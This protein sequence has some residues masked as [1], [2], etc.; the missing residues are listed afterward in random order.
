MHTMHA[1]LINALGLL[2]PLSAFAQ[3]GTGGFFQFF[4]GKDIDYWNEGK[5]VRDPLSFAKD[6]LQNQE[7]FEKSSYSGSTLIRS[8]DSK[9]FHWKNYHD[10]RTPEFWDDGGDWIPPRPFREAAAHPTPENIQAYLQWQVEKTR[11]VERFQKELEQLVFAEK[12]NKTQEID[13]KTL[14]I[15]Y[16][17]QSSCSSCRSSAAVVEKAKN[18]GARVTFVQLDF[19]DNPPLHENSIPYDAS[20]QQNFSVQLTPTWLIKQGDEIRTVTGTL[21]FDELIKTIQ[22]MTK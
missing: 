14:H 17:Y 15:A 2:T 4:H 19:E 10:P 18:R 3:E 12:E 16:F 6:P 1:L 11:V 20:W 22:N 7:V 21:T 13:W 8:G 9:P 5:Q